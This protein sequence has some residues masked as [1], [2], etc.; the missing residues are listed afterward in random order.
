MTEPTSGNILIVEDEAALRE[1]YAT[2]LVEA[3][4]RVETAPDGRQ[5]MDLLGNASV[6]LTDISM[7][8]MTASSCCA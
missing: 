6:I 4:H 7:P 1:L 2:L 5:A 8:D 3:G